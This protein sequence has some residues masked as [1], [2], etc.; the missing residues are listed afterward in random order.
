MS[1]HRIRSTLMYAQKWTLRPLEETVFQKTLKIKNLG[2]H[3]H[4][5]VKPKR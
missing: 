5:Q 2:Y 4:E 3:V 1:I